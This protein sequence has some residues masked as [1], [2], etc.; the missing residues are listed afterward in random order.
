MKIKAIIPS[1]ALAMAAMAGVAHAQTI[2][3]PT[4]LNSATDGD[5][6][7]G[8]VNSANPPGAGDLD[9]D[10]GSASQYTGLVGGSVHTV[11]AFSTADLSSTYG[12]NAFSSTTNWTVF[13]GNGIAGGP[14][15]TPTDALWA[16]SVNSSA[17]QAKTAT[18]QGATSVALDGFL[19]S[20]V[21]G[22]GNAGGFTLNGSAYASSDSGSSATGASGG[23]LAQLA[24]SSLNFGY[25]SS[26]VFKPTAGTS[27]LTLYQLL[28][29]SSGTAPGV[30]LGF[31]TLSNSGLTFTA[32]T[33]IPE[34]STYAAILGLLTI[35]FVIV[36]RRFQT[37]GLGAMV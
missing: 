13:G 11:A 32:F 12:A 7:L 22:F 3:G 19:N 8:F 36:R 33:A 31:F 14:G 23:G 10:I 18:A 15:S 20:G 24:G 16:T 1:L 28:P 6:I 17:L 2:N 21:Q 25:F 29:T 26:S 9:V 4:D 5:L 30:D 27:T 37:A 34:P 35:G